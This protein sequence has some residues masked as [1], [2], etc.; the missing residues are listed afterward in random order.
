MDGLNAQVTTVMCAGLDLNETVPFW[1]AVPGLEEVQR[2]GRSVP[3]RPVSHGGPHHAFQPVPE[4]RSGKNRLHLDG[5]VPG[6]AE[7][8]RAIVTA[9]GSVLNRIEEPG[10]PA[11]TVVAGPAGDEFCIY[12]ASGNPGQER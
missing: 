4:P 12:V 8:E 6:R 11:W 2:T 7:A 5:R 1:S 9:P 3:L 10:F